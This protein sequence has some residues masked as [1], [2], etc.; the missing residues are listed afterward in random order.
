[1]DLRDRH[2]AGEINRHGLAVAR[3]R[4]DNQLSNL[5]FLGKANA[6]NARLAL[7]LWA[8]RAD[9]FRFLRK[10]GLDATN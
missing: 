6:A 7:H 9:L 3:A 2:A 5:I 8:H 10:P 1:L 4:L